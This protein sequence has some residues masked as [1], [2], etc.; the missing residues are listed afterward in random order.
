MEPL[1][2]VQ[3]R[4]AGRIVVEGCFET[5]GSRCFPLTLSQEPPKFDLDDYISKYKGR[6]YSTAVG[7]DF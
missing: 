2:F 4:R 7:L 3:A 6:I 1:Y 5:L